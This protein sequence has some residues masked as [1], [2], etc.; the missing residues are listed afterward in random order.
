[1]RDFVGTSFPAKETGSEPFTDHGLEGWPLGGV[2]QPP[3]S[4]EKDKL[5]FIPWAPSPL[6]FNGSKVG[7]SVGFD[8]RPRAQSQ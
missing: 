6:L 3:Q 8:N 4:K 1:M 2:R 5:E 7:P